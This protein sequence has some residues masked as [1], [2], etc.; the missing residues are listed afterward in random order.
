MKVDIDTAPGGLC[1]LH[2]EQTVGGT[3]TA[4]VA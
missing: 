3:A 2:M 4:N 1:P